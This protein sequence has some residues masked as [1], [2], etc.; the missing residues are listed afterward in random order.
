MRKAVLPATSKIES[1]LSSREILPLAT[2]LKLRC[3]SEFPSLRVRTIGNGDVDRQGEFVLYWMIA[4]R[5]TRWN[6]S[7]QRARDWAVE[8]KKPLVV[9]EALRAG[10]P[11]A[12]DRLHAFV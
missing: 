5:R 2:S 7:L 12:S 10:Y 3:M 1:K 6:F 9:F 8:L 11:W 4:N